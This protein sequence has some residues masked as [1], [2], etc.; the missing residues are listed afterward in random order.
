MLRIWVWVFHLQILGHSWDRDMP[1]L[2]PCQSYGSIFK[3]QYCCHAK[4]SLN[5]TVSH[6]IC[7]HQTDKTLCTMVWGLK[8]LWSSWNGSGKAFH[9]PSYFLEAPEATLT[10]HSHCHVNS[11]VQFHRF[12]NSWDMHSTYANCSTPPNSPLLIF[13]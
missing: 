9:T 1:V 2:L 11:L 8:I 13:H 4:G 5:F 3:T 12:R 7:R 10:S 6:I